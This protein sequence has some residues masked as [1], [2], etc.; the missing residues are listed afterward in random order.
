MRMKNSVANTVVCNFV[1]LFYAVN[2]PISFLSLTTVFACILHILLC[3]IGVYHIRS[4]NWR[5]VGIYNRTAL[6]R[7]P[8]LL[9]ISC[10]VSS[11]FLHSSIAS[12]FFSW[13]LSL[14]FSLVVQVLSL[15][16][17]IG[18]R[19]FKRDTRGGYTR[20]EDPQIK[21]IDEQE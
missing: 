11:L 14:S 6:I 10:F 13:P 16:I 18:R 5:I 12:F 2:T 7:G 20:Y 8:A 21:K 3:L 9:R 19:T 17:L 4:L 15:I 1:V